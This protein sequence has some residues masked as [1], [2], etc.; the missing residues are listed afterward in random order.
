MSR[1]GKLPVPV[2]SGVDIA[3]DGQ[4]VTVKGPR[5]TLSH[6][7][8]QPIN[9][10]KGEDGMIAV[11]RPDDERESKS[12]HGLSR[13]LIANMVTGVTTG[14]SKTLEIVGTGYR[15][16]ARGSDLEFALGFSHPVLV[17]A[18]TGITFTVERPTLFHVAGIDKQQVG[19]V[20]ANIRKIRPPEPYKGKG[21]KYQG[22]VIRRKA[23]KAGKK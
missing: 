20:A 7:V 12:L 14:Y 10:S 19:E 2:P 15:V 13:T 5:G 16:T 1:I 18:P 17:P 22:E 9:V 6:T 4:V 11:T 8:A 3:I 23:G 21:V